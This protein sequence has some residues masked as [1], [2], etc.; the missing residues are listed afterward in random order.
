MYWSSRNTNARSWTDGIES[1]VPES[2]GLTRHL[3]CLPLIELAPVV[4]RQ[5][6]L[7]MSFLLSGSCL[8]STDYATQLGSTQFGS[9]QLNLAQHNSTWLSSTQLGSTQLG[10]TQVGSTPLNSTWLNSTQLNSTQL[11]GT[12]Q[13]NSTRWYSRKNVA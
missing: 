12:A 1:T 13:L 3:P 7:P 8:D 9:T 4:Q 2:K 11:D 6:T 10:S 5:S